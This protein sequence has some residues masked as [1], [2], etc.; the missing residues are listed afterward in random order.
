MG[1]LSHGLL[2]G[3][4]ERESEKGRENEGGRERERESARERVS[5]SEGARESE[6]DN[7][8]VECAGAAR[9]TSSHWYIKGILS[10]MP[11]DC[12]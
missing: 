10:G 2:Q 5:E 6:K 3:I 9:D 4:P 8:Q 11:S 12:H 7:C 1:L